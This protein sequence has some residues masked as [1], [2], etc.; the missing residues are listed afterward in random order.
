MASA[1]QAHD[2][3]MQYCMPL[4]GYFLQ[5]SRYD[6]LTTIRTSD[7][8]FNRKPAGMIF[9]TPRVWPVHWEYGRGRMCL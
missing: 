8:R 2:L 9:F 1:L 4:P 7:D 5:G 3:T 6:N